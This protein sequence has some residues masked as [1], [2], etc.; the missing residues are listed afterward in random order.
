M[1]S[2]LG[3]II[4]T[5]FFISLVVG[6][7]GGGFIL[8]DNLGIISDLQ[9][10]TPPEEIPGNSPRGT[11]SSSPEDKDIIQA[12]RNG[13]NGRTYTTTA[14]RWESQD[15]QCTHQE[16]ASDI[17]KNNPRLA[18]CPE[19]GHVYQKRQYV[20]ET[21]THRCGTLPE[22]GWTVTS[23]EE[24]S[25]R[26]SHG[27]SSWIVTKVDG[28]RAAVEGWIEIGVSDFSFWVKPNQDC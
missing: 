12:V 6:L 10:G 7:I 19:V 2:C 26:A 16:V 27:G 24:D 25:W 9:S 23:L 5:I 3:R 18:K 28:G 15:H 8:A 20:S 4:K 11:Y 22:T 21:E 13:V 17:Y 14:G 1:F